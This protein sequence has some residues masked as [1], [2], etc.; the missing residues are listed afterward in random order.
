[1]K[2]IRMSIPRHQMRKYRELHSIREKVETSTGQVEPKNPYGD[3]YLKRP[4]TPEEKVLIRQFIH[5][6]GEVSDNW[7]DDE[8]GE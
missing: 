4:L 5:E 2:K 6:G 1:M 8:Y 3:I 7:Q